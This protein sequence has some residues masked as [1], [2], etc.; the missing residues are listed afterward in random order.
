MGGV[1]KGGGR[2]GVAD[3]CRMVRCNGGSA[4][5]CESALLPAYL[6][7]S[8]TRRRCEVMSGLL[9]DLLSDCL[10]IYLESYRK[11]DGGGAEFLDT[12]V[13]IHCFYRKGSPSLAP[14]PTLPPPKPPALTQDTLM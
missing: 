9:A 11:L 1:A 5:C 3:S 8:P 14:A 4:S 13:S 6:D 12:T 2:G 10:K 7:Q